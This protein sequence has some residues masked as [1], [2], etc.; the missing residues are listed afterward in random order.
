MSPDPS[1]EKLPEFQQEAARSEGK[2]P[3]QQDKLDHEVEYK[4]GEGEQEV[5]DNE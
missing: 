5:A 1:P 2:V 4:V 3:S